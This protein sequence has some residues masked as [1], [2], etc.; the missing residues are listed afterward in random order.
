MGDSRVISARV[1]KERIELVEAIARAEKVDRSTVL[2]RA[3]EHYTQE[4]RLQKALK[5]YMEGHVTLSRAAE[6][7]GLSIWEMID[8][9]DKRR[10]SPQYDIEDLEDDL[11]ALR[12]ERR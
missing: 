5:S 9:I 7:A 10:I 1:S 2:D 8:V 3:L 11:K 6:V 4:W 12:N